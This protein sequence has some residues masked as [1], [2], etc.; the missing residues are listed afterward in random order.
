MTLYEKGARFERFLVNKFHENGWISFR[1]AG[2]G[3]MK[4]IIPDIIA[5]KGR[6]VLMIECKT[7]KKRG[8][9][10]KETILELKKI[11][12]ISEFDIYIA[13]KF[14]RKEPRF[15][16][17]QD[18]LKKKNFTISINDEYKVFEEIIV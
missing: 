12:P 10:L 1:S 17:I 8:I 4:F 15:Y 3:I 9:S 5:I 6:K 11:L 16:K 7:T 2:S 13:V 18:L 14:N